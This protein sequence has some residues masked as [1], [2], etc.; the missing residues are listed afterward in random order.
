MQQEKSE[1]RE[2]KRKLLSCSNNAVKMI[3]YLLTR[4]VGA[5]FVAVALASGAVA[6]E[7][8]ALRNA[9]GI[10][11]STRRTKARR[12]QIA[13]FAGAVGKTA[14]ARGTWMFTKIDATE[15]G[16]D[17]K[18]IVQVDDCARPATGGE[19]GLW[20]G[21]AWRLVRECGHDRK[22]V[23]QVDDAVPHLDPRRKDIAVNLTTTA[24]TRNRIG[25]CVARVET[26]SGVSVQATFLIDPIGEAR[27]SFATGTRRHLNDGRAPVERDKSAHRIRIST[28]TN[29]RR[30]IFISI[31]A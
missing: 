11:H 31:G 15:G 2:L 9:V 1:R 20:K 18:N 8:S 14:R 7:D 21:D 6:L 19:V 10:R 27:S 23:I 24:S 3:C 30:A 16:E 12:G 22:D 29:A 26:R 13:I 5:V 17:D 28:A 4:V 25:A